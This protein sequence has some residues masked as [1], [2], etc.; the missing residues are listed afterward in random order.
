MFL[1]PFG[2][3]HLRSYS[4]L[5]AFF[6]QAGVFC[7]VTCL[8]SPRSPAGSPPLLC[9]FLSK[10][11]LWFEEKGRKLQ[12]SCSCF[13]Q[14]L[15][16][17][18]PRFPAFPSTLILSW[19]NCSKLAAPVIA[20]STGWLRSR[21]NCRPRSSPCAAS[22]SAGTLAAVQAGSRLKFGGCEFVF[23]SK[24]RVDQNH[25]HIFAKKYS[26]LLYYVNS[27]WVSKN[28]IQRQRDLKPRGDTLLQTPL[29]GLP[30]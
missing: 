29:V 4:D 7:P 1:V 18:Q 14:W 24:F 30:P 8:L 17:L 11:S 16:L 21:G 9:D 12:W 3:R 2:K 13:F 6:L 10:H 5:G 25:L 23:F 26:H 22:F 20:P 28:K 19:R 15:Q 27:S